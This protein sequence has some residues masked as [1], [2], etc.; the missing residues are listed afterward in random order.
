MRNPN[1]AMYDNRTLG[2]VKSAQDRFKSGN[3]V[4]SKEILNE[5]KKSFF[6]L[7]KRY[8]TDL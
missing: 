6:F 1:K 4:H 7:L 8:T 3:I 2:M 5:E